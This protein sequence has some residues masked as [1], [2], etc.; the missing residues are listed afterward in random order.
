MTSKPGSIE[1][2]MQPAIP[3]LVC[4]SPLSMRL[5]KGRK[6]GNPSV[7]LICGKDGRHFRGFIAYQPFVL[8]VL[9]RLEGLQ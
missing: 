2:N 4:H 3:C 6:S 7:M 1:K 9:D 8:E 5:T